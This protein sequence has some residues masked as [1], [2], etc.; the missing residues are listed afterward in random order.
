M[1]Y[2]LQAFF[3]LAVLIALP[4]VVEAPTSTAGMLA[5]ALGALILVGAAFQGVAGFVRSRKP[6]AYPDSIIPPLEPPR[7]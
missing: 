4:S 1:R 2:L 7:K 5:A 3:A 6:R